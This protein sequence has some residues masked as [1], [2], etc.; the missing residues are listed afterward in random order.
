MSHLVWPAY[1]RLLHSSSFGAKLQ[2]LSFVLAVALLGTDVAAV[3][4]GPGQIYQQPSSELPVHGSLVMSGGSIVARADGT[5][6]AFVAGDDVISGGTI[7]AQLRLDIGTKM[8]SGGVFNQRLQIDRASAVVISGG[9]FNGTVDIDRLEKG[10]TLE[11][12]GGTFND[13]AFVFRMQG[14]LIVRGGRFSSSFFA[15]GSDNDNSI[16]TAT[17]V[18]L[19]WSFNGERLPFSVNTVDLTGRTGVLSG[20]LSDGNPFSVAIGLPFGIT[21]V[22]AMLVP[23]PESALLVGITFLALTASSACRPDRGSPE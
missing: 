11:I 14:D 18:G 19:D 22:T 20:R 12:S 2:I 17:F 3:T 23:E 21:R 15:Q 5:T 8:I 4:I 6:T 13:S 9:E 10:G 7:D 1:L 16:P